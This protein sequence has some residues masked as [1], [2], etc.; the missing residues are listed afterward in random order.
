MAERFFSGLRRIK[1]ESRE[2]TLHLRTEED[3]G[4]GSDQNSLPCPLLISVVPKVKAV[5]IMLNQTSKNFRLK[6]TKCIGTINCKEKGSG[7]STL[8]DGS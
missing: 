7:T 6:R 3:K 5:E 8:P 1:Y 2:H 4:H